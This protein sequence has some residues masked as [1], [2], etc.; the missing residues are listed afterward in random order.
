MLT[1][2]DIRV[3][4]AGHTVLRGVSFTLPQGATTV[5][6]GRNGAGKTTTLR[7][8]MGLVPL[9]GGRLT[10]DGTDLAAQPDHARAGLGIGYAPEDRRMIPA[11]SVEDNLLLPAVALKMPA[12]ISA[13]RLA[14][15]YELMPELTEL[16]NRPGGSLSGGQGKMV[17][18]GRALMVATRAILL[19]EPF[20]GL[21]P[22]LALNYARTLAKVRDARGDLALLVTESSP[23]LLA[24]VADRA[25]KIERG[26]VS[27]TTLDALGH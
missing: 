22:A 19:D 4:L 21:A 18:L 8:I 27:E 1:L 14:M 17:A 26:E 20:Q 10:L 9:G 3:S 16:K 24:G 23:Q 13:E 5:L 2:D 12:G 15:V 25:L 6:V 7:T 11:F